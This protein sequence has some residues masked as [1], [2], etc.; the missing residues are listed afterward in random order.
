M[1]IKVRGGTTVQ[2]DD[3]LC[4]TCRHSKIIR[5]RRLEEHIVFCGGIGLEPVR[6]TFKVTGC[7]DYVDDAEPT[8]HELLEKAWILRPPNKRRAAGFVRSSDL[9]TQEAAQLFDDPTE[10]E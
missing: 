10:K 7:T 5:G 1:L 2:H 3:A 9:T 8:Y 6:V 4:D